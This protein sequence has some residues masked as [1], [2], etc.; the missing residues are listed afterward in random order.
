MSYY[1]IA[2]FNTYGKE[3]M[4]QPFYHYTVENTGQTVLSLN[5][6]TLYNK[7][8]DSGEI[9]K[10]SLYRINKDLYQQNKYIL[11]AEKNFNPTF[12]NN[13]GFEKIND[14]TYIVNK[15]NK[16]QI[17]NGFH[18]DFCYHQ[19]DNMFGN[20]IYIDCPTITFS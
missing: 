18:L 19:N 20:K 12:V 10:F 4:T 3:W 11:F 7:L 16:E 15:N 14:F 13:I 17:C 1:V 5:R 8:V 2:D 9:I 6:D